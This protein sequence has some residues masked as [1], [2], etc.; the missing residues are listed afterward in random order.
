MKFHYPLVK[1]VVQ[2][3]ELIFGEGKY[4]DKVIEHCL[5]KNPKWGARDRRFIAEYTYDIVRNYRLLYESAG[6]KSPWMLVAAQMLVSGQQ[7]PEWKEF[8]GITPQRILRNFEA[9]KTNF[10][11]AQS[12]PGWLDEMGRKELGAAWEKEMAALNSEAPVVL[13][14]NTLKTSA[15]KLRKELQQAGIETEVFPGIPEAL[16]LRQRQNLFSTPQ[17]KNGLFEIQD[18]S[19][20]RVAHFMQVNEQMRV[21]DAC[22]GAGGKTLH[23]A[24]LLKNKGKVI[25]MDVEEWKLNELKKRAVRAG[26][27]NIETRLAESKEIGRL[28]QSADRLL[29]DVPCSGTG[30]LRRNPDAKWKLSPASIEKVKQLQEKI[31]RDYAVMVKPGG[32]LIYATCSILPSE[33]SEQVKKFL[34]AHP[35]FSFEEEKVILPS[36]GADGFYMCRMCFSPNPV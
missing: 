6:T 13:R 15:E 7:L 31:L 3:L 32:K 34:D 10:A 9:G 18:L 35:S 21:V 29:L 19:S 20:Q 14:A 27:H 28:K 36:S 12:I 26:A 30:V 17:F 25:S 5:K 24:A 33:N 2:N 16:I 23:I 11:I 4:A 22:A 1:A 8:A